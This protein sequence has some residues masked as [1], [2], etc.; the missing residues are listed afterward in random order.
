MSELLKFACTAAI[1]A[2]AL[3][4]AAQDDDRI[5]ALENQIR[6]M[7][8]RLDAI[9]EADAANR[10]PEWLDQVHGKGLTIGFYGEAKYNM[11]KGSNGNYFDPHRFVLIPGFKLS[12]N[13]YFNSEIEIEHGGVDDKDDSRFRGE[14]EIEQ[15]YSDVKINDWL[16]WRSLGVSLIPVGSINLHHEPDQFYS[17]HRPIMYK[18]IVPST[19]MEGSM[20]LFGDVPQVEG[21]SWFFLVS[22][23]LSSENGTFADGSKGVRDARPNLNAKGDNRQLA[24]TMRL[25][26]DG[27]SSDTDW[28]KGLSGS[29]SSYFGNYQETTTTDTDVYLWDIEAKYRWHSGFMNNFELIGDYAQWHFASPDAIADANVGDRMFGYRLELA[30]HHVL[31]GDQELIPFFRL[32]GYDTSEGSKDSNAFTD[33]GSSNYLTY[34][35]YYQLN[36]HMEL[37]AA[38]RQS[39]DDVD[40][41][42]FSIGVGYQF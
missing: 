32:E 18:Y 2:S 22:Q 10:P 7:Q 24:Y 33:T 14:V 30:Y 6:A 39:M 40:N 20:G 41:T 28:L 4:G 34:G 36:R 16:N 11:T 3:N 19:W 37:K 42:E 5:D 21:L 27:A 31:E 1:L 29:A 35:V 26:Y 12:D 13:A 15:F 17:V 25:E 38:V 9:K 23:G 8:Q